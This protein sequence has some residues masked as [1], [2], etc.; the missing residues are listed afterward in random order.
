MKI[1]KKWSMPNGNTFTIKPIKEL[2]LKYIKEKDIIL[3][4]FANEPTI[5]NYIPKDCIFI[6]NDLN[7][8]YNTTYHLEATE[9]FKKFENNSVDV[10]LYDP[11][12]SSRQVKEC[13]EIIKKTVT[14]KDTQSSYWSKFKKEI[15]RILKPNG[16]C[17]SFMLNTNGIGKSN[18]FEQIEILIVSHGGMHNDTLCCVERKK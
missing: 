15:A 3:D 5:N 1:T 17:I 14:T 6:S 11:P 9:F 7:E 16:I 4:P 8:K 13:Y 12:Y 2:I 18:G 10:I